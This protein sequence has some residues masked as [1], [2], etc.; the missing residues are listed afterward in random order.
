MQRAQRV[1]RLCF[2]GR[3]SRARLPKAVSLTG[4][5]VCV[6]ASLLQS[7]KLFGGKNAKP[8]MPQS[9]HSLRAKF[10]FA[11]A[12]RPAHDFISVSGRNAFVSVGCVEAFHFRSSLVRTIVK[13]LDRWP[14]VLCTRAI[15]H[16]TA[17]CLSAR[18]P[19]RL[20][21]RARENFR[22]PAIFPP[23]FGG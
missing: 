4:P 22:A 2:A 9:Q 12:G 8:E 15:C 3:V 13:R 6:C 7:T 23:L 11:A 10:H 14:T 16:F 20:R 19:A 18:V 17:V 5:Q 21:V 1:T